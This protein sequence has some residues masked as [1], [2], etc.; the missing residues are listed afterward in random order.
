VKRVRLACRI[1][2]PFACVCIQACAP[3][4]PIPIAGPLDV[5]GPLPV[6]ADLAARYNARVQ[7]LDRLWSRTVIT[8]NYENKEG[9]PASE[10]L[11]GHF[12]YRAPHGLILTFMKAGQ[13]GGIMGCGTIDRGDEGFWWIDLQDRRH[14]LVGTLS[15]VPEARLEEFGV[16]VHPLDLIEL[17]A[18]TPLPASG[19]GLRLDRSPDSR[20]IIVASPGRRAETSRRVWIDPADARPARIEL[21]RGE[22]VVLWSE[23]AKFAPVEWRALPRE[24]V[25]EWRVPSDVT[26]SL[27]EGRVRARMTLGEPESGG[28]KPKPEVF[29]LSTWLEGYGVR[30]IERLDEASGTR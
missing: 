9:K 7:G 17:M 21:V 25:R 12:N 13:L 30:E 10:Q 26:I 4:T 16:P 28:A 18:L 20:F 8:L 2:I 5:V 29:S 15:G 24:G 1:L 3:R 22:R 14:A 19:E 27:D 6:Y 23:F 11:E